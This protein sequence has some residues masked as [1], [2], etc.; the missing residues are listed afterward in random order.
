MTEERFDEIIKEIREEAPPPEQ[1]SEAR[2]RVW[3]QIS[4]AISVACDQFR[5]DFD[6]YRAGQLSPGCPKAPSPLEPPSPSAISYAPAPVP[7]PSCNS[8]TAHASSSISAPSFSSRQLGA[9]RPY[10]STAATSSCRPPSSAAAI[11][12]S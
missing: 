12:A 7:T 3:R 10:T 11:C 5:P 1:V 4:G 6:A 9:A 2:E 8:P